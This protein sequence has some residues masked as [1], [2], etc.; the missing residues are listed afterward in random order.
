MVLWCMGFRLSLINHNSENSS[1]FVWGQILKGIPV[2]NI[3]NTSVLFKS[4]VSLYS[5]FNSLYV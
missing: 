4:S 3:V 5:E 2:N 1:K